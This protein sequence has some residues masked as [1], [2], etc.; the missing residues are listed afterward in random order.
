MLSRLS[1]LLIF[2]TGL[3]VKCIWIRSNKQPG[4]KQFRI[5]FVLSD[6]SKGD[7][8]YKK[9]SFS[10][11]SPFS[12]KKAELL[13]C[14]FCRTSWT[15]PGKWKQRSVLSLPWLLFFKTTISYRSVLNDK[16]KC[17][18]KTQLLLTFSNYFYMAFS[19]SKGEIKKTPQ[20][21]LLLLTF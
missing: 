8:L 7:L 4:L 10:Q 6:F 14:M 2:K 11:F 16:H 13:I 1:D 3:E 21:F 9:Q 20:C 5:T 19:S 12:R 17:V 18:G 15:P